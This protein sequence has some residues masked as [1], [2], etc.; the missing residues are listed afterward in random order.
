MGPSGLAFAV[1]ATVPQLCMAP[2][3]EARSVRPLRW[4]PPKKPKSPMEYNGLSDMKPAC[5]KMNGGDHRPHSVYVIGDWGG[6]LYGGS[7]VAPADHRSMK[8]KAHHRAF[9]KG[10]GGLVALSFDTPDIQRRGM[11]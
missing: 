5:F 10:A 6:V 3:P 1:A 7:W 2:P 4:Y 11:A 8:F 9:V